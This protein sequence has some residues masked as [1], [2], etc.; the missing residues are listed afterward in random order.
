MNMINVEGDLSH[1]YIIWYQVYSTEQT[2]LN[3]RADPN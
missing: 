3:T 1:Q 2:Q